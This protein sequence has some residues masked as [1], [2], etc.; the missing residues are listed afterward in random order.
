MTGSARPPGAALSRL[1][2]RVSICALV[3]VGL[4]AV[5]AHR[6]SGAE[7]GA[8]HVALSHN[9]VSLSLIHLDRAARW[10][11]P[12][13]PHRG[14][15][16]R[17]LA[18]MAEEAF[19]AGDRG[20]ATRRLRVARGAHQSA[21]RF[22]DDVPDVS[23]RLDTLSAA[24]A[25]TRRENMT[26]RELPSVAFAW[27]SLLGFAGLLL[28]A[29]AYIREGLDREGRTQATGRRYAWAGVGSALLWL[30][31]LWLA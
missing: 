27:M 17:G 20:E 28:C 29:F 19:E 25:G 16:L 23:A 18:T 22:Y 9:D 12:F 6:E 13:S 30:L 2:Y 5:R 1:A 21:T 14:V 10:Y 31:G 4:L 8:A 3:V 11:A 7:L 26:E 15:A 24:L